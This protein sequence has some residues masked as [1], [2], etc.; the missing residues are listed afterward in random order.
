MMEALGCS[1][2]V[3]RTKPEL[4]Y[5]HS[6]RI[7]LNNDVSMDCKMAYLEKL[8]SEFGI[9]YEDV[10]SSDNI[11]SIVG[12]FEATEDIEL[13]DGDPDS[14]TSFYDR[15]R[16]EFYDNYLYI[17]VELSFDRLV[18]F[19]TF[20]I[21]LLKNNLRDMLVYHNENPGGITTA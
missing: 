19:H 2:P 4:Q 10:I 12:R 17:K 6:A 15:C 7:E 20:T 5:R 21:G 16:V 8:R 13:V 11:D 14:I 3:A 18:E 9:V 1:F